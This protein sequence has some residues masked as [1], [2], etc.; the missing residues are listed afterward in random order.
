MERSTDFRL[1]QNLLNQNWNQLRIDDTNYSFKCL[2]TDNAYEILIFDL[3][4]MSLYFTK[5][6][7][8]EILELLKVM[9]CQA[10]I[11]FCSR[12]FK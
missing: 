8:N 10:L 7:E 11:L 2:F 4:D 1:T 12:K 5:K 3:N 9:H 6:N